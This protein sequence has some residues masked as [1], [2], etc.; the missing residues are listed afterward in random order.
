MREGADGIISVA[1]NVIPKQIKELRN[2]CFSKK[3]KKQKQ[4]MRNI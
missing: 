2:V 4:L 1:A 3:L